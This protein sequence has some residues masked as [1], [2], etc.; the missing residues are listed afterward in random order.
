MSNFWKNSSTFYS[1][2]K[3]HNN[4]LTYLRFEGL[5]DIV[6]LVKLLNSCKNLH[7][8]PIKNRDTVSILYFRMQIMKH[9]VNILYFAQPY[10]LYY[11]TVLNILYFSIFYILFL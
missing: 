1:S 8:F 3:E 6:L 7:T 9:T 11:Y 5:S 10:K 2:I 4:S